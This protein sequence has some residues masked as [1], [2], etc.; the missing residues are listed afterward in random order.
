MD[1][2]YPNE[3][4]DFRAEIKAW[5]LDN[6]P[7]GWFDDGF[8]MTPDQRE[9]FNAEWPTKLFEGGWICATWPAEYGGKGLSTM[10]GRCIVGRVRQREGPDAR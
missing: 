9:A 2:T 5:L 3:A 4:E 1:L 10:Q 8:E 6:L 7:G